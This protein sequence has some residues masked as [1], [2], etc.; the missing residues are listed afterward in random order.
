MQKKTYFF[1]LA[2]V[3]PSGD[4]FDCCLSSTTLHLLAYPLY[5]NNYTGWETAFL[6]CFFGHKSLVAANSRWARNPLQMAFGCAHSATAQK[7]QE[8]RT[9]VCGEFSFTSVLPTGSLGSIRLWRCQNQ[10]QTCCAERSPTR[11][12]EHGLSPSEGLNTF[13]D[14]H[15]LPC[16]GIS[17]CWTICGF[18][19]VW[20]NTLELNS[21]GK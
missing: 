19:E 13:Y 2:P 1:C 5:W 15:P 8:N 18:G 10:H 9:L 12:N 17:S 6:L 20:L 4:I 16:S 3:H 7:Q 11:W 21:L 14:T